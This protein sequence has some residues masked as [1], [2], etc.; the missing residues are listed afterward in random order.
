[1]VPIPAPCPRKHS[2]L[3]RADE[4]AESQHYT[5]TRIGSRWL[6][7]N[8]GGYISRSVNESQPSHA[9]PL[10]CHLFTRH[11]AEWV[12]ADLAL[13]LV[14]CLIGCE[15]TELREPSGFVIVVCIVG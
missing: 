4:T 15:R 8:T 5:L 10:L 14:V 7:L 13:R 3:N 1:M 12:L 2:H 6:I 11:S 9:P